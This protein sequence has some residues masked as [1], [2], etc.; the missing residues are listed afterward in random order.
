MTVVVFAAALIPALIATMCC[1]A[2]AEE[3]S[4][5]FA[6]GSTLVLIVRALLSEEGRMTAAVSAEVKTVVSIALE[7]STAQQWQTLV[8]FAAEM[9]SST[10]AVSVMATMHA[11]A[12]MESAILCSHVRSIAAECV[13]ELTV[14]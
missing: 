12:V 5:M 1:T 8:E 14:V 11:V 4:A 13:A 7:L 6:T 2:P 9:E 3:T 10:I